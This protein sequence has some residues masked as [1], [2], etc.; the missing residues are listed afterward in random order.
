MRRLLVSIVA[1][2]FLVV[3]P[4]SAQNIGI[5]FDPA[6]VTCSGGVPS[7]PLRCYIIA[8]LGGP[9]AAG[10]TGAEFKVV[11]LPP[12]W[13][14]NS[15]PNPTATV[16]LGGPFS[17]IGTNIAFPACQTTSLVPLFT[18][19]LFPSSAVTNHS[20]SVQ[21]RTPPTNP[22]FVCP[23]V[24]RCDAPNFTI[25]CCSGGEAI[26]NPTGPGCTVPVRERAGP[27]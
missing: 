25:V 18:V 8:A 9:A 24:T 13:F 5:F 26:L 15:T 21:N 6:A 20:L 27:R 3:A 12:D 22:N 2:A 14:E 16:V 11:G 10:I 23:L 7:G 17:E 4:A 19:D 1:L